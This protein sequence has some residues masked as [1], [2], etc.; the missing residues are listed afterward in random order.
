MIKHLYNMNRCILCH[1]L[2]TME[3]WEKAYGCPNPK[4]VSGDISYVQRLEDYVMYRLR[5][6]DE[7]DGWRWQDAD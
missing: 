1:W 6:Q 2:F 7:S 4:C 5:I 3:E